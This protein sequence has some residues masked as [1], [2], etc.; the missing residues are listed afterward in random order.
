MLNSVNPI[1]RFE[2]NFDNVNHDI[3]KKIRRFYPELSPT[4]MRVCKLIGLNYS[5]KEI[6]EIFNL[7]TRTVDTHRYKIR[8]KLNLNKNENLYI[9]INKVLYD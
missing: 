2:N 1:K 7:S 5:T 3:M 4:E 9:T 6:A 8:K